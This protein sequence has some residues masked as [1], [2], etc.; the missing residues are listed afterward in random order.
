MVAAYLADPH[1]VLN[2]KVF[3]RCEQSE[4]LPLP[5]SNAETL[6]AIKAYFADARERYD[7][8]K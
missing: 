7:R 5:N 4:G 8:K 2:N 3:V 1:D 6:D